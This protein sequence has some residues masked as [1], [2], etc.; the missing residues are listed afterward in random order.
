MGFL[1]NNCL[2]KVFDYF[3]RKSSGA[4]FRVVFIYDESLK[5][6]SINSE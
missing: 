4:E 2:F 3:G 6:I 5:N 1:D